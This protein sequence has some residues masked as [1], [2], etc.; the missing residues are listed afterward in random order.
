MNSEFVDAYEENFNVK[1]VIMTY[2]ANRCRDLGKILSI[3]Y[4][5]GLFKRFA[6]GL[7]NGAWHFGYPK[8][9]YCYEL[10]SY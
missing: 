7:S 2:G 3:G 6:T 4:K 9:V 8:W 5:I 1:V 10:V